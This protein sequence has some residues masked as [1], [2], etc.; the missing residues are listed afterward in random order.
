MLLANKTVLVT[1]GA[2][3]IGSHLV[4]A[5]I[6][7]EPGCLIVVDNL[8]L[9]S[10]DNLA[11]AQERFPEI[12]F[13]KQNAADLET[14]A[15]ICREYHV[16]VIFN[17]AVV[18]LPKCLEDP[19]FT[20]DEN[21]AIVTTLCELAHRGAYDCLIHFSS[22]EVYGSAQ[23]GEM[24]EGHPTIPHTP[25]AASK[26]AGDQII[27]SHQKTFGMDASILRP[28]NNYGPRQNKASYA[29]VIPKVIEACLRNEEITVYGDGLQTRDFMYVTDT[30]RAA[31]ECYQRPQTRG[32]V[33]NVGTGR[34]TKILDLIKM[35]LRAA[36][37]DPDDLVFAESRPGDVRR[38]C[39]DISLARKL[40]GFHP[41][42]KLK[43]GLRR[44]VEWYQNNRS[45]RSG[46][47]IESPG[48]SRP[49]TARSDDT[50]RRVIR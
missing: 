45:T 35:L 27:F 30:V 10:E 29:G 36:G 34:E 3:F 38:H 32:K 44:T 7:Q 39:A 12:L 33:I 2:G 5:L 21:V 1:G 16:E 40:L 41:E 8:F 11:P 23:A 17:L 50:A 9:G 37:R 4:D 6:E 13:L 15:S 46:D 18:P 24:S 26:L 25:Y 43:D 47:P 48:H 31:I 49:A 19:K 28:F 14:M 20:V 42:M 22:S